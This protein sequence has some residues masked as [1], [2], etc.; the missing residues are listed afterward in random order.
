MHHR[1]HAMVRVLDYHR[2]TKVE[3]IN[4]QCFLFNFKHDGRATYADVVVYLH[5]LVKKTGIN[6]KL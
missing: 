4:H 5:Y 6:K 2:T 1:T 3:I